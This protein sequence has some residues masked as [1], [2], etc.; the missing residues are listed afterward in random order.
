[1][2]TSGPAGLFA[3]GRLSR[4]D[5]PHRVVMAPL[6]RNRA[7]ADG[8][9]SALA[10]EYYRQRASAALIVSEATSVS[11]AGAGYP[12]TPG[13]FTDAH[14]EGWRRVTSAVHAAGGRIFAQ[15]CHNGRISHSSFHDGAW[16]VAPSAIAAPGHAMTRDD[17]LV[18]FETPRALA[19]A[20]VPEVVEQ[21]AQAARRALAAG[22]DGVELHAASGFLLDQFLRDGTNRRTDRYG[23]PLEHRTR[24]LL[25]VVDVVGRACGPD[26]VGVRL[27]PLSA[28]NGMADSHPRDTFGFVAA[29]LSR[30][31]LAYLHLMRRNDVAGAA[32]AFDVGTLR[33]VYDG[34]LILN[35]GFDRASGDHAIRSGRADFISYGTAFLANPDLPARFR[36][37]AILNVPDKAT[38]YAGG[39]RGY[40][41]YP[42][43]V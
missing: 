39:A 29:E 22:F 42:A 28:V 14:V 15:L 18:P 25:D 3:A 13:L 7:G 38:L 24:F 40:V 34:T 6:T 5:V 32:E 43:I 21:F 9:Q 8:T 20:D 16:P 30:A 2:T 36:T 19:I 1:M 11:P 4:Y 12:R 33:D 10:V 41:D 17:E 26:R 23:G 31:G 35:G 27:S 37:G